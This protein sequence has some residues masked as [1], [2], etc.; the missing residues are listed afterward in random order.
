M[1]YSGMCVDKRNFVYY[2]VLHRRSVVII[3][4]R[5]IVIDCSFEEDNIIINKHLLAWRKIHKD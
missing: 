4:E 5:G 3:V 2:P 1:K